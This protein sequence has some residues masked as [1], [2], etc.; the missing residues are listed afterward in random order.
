MKYRKE[1]IKEGI[2]KTRKCARS[3]KRREDKDERIEKEES[4]KIK[5]QKR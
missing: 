5:Q 1:E 4:S 2:N 3:N